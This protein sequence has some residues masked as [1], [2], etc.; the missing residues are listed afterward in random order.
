MESKSIRISNEVYE[1]LDAIRAKRETFSEVVGR[2]ITIHDGLGTLTTV[3]QGQ[4]E[5]REFQLEKLKGETPAI[6]GVGNYLKEH[7]RGGIP[8][9]ETPY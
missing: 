5:Y 6:K 9:E 2:L 4:K 7:P 3:I 8:A 1:K